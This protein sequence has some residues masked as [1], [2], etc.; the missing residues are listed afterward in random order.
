MLPALIFTDT[1]G[2]IYDHAISYTVTKGKNSEREL[3]RMDIVFTTRSDIS[4]KDTE[5]CIEEFTNILRGISIEIP[6]VEGTEYRNVQT[7]AT[8]AKE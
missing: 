2:V 6:E 8:S 7:D 5:K 3:S 1:P 4:S